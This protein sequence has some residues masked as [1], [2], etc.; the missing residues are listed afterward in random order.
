MHEMVDLSELK[1]A[2]EFG[3]G[4]LVVKGAH[5]WPLSHFVWESSAKNV[6]ATFFGDAEP[7][8]D[9]ANLLRIEVYKLPGRNAEFNDRLEWYTRH[10]K[11]K[12]I[13]ISDGELFRE[14]TLHLK[15][16]PSDWA[17]DSF[18]LSKGEVIRIYQTKK[19]AI[20]FRFLARSGTLLDHPIFKRVVKNIS[21]DEHR[22]V[23]SVPD[24]VETRPK[25]K[26]SASVPLSDAAMQEVRTSVESV[27]KRLKL[28]RI[29][30]TGKKWKSFTTRSIPHEP[31]RSLIKISE[32]L[33]RLK[34]AAL[35]DKCSARKW[36][37]NGFKF[38]IRTGPR[39]L[40]LSAAIVHWPWIPSV[41]Y[42]S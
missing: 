21:F 33:W 42:M 37:G 1:L 40:R 12:P 32:F 2:K 28:S 31:T 25:S 23:Q 41:G 19:F 5:L 35:S 9:A 29:K 22:W 27:M 17:Q 6:G 36:T 26:R 10:R 18:A 39:Q 8:W 34:W 24:V 3:I 15:G 11:S 38:S 20:I 7:P 16:L 4:C 14:E 13:K 30:D